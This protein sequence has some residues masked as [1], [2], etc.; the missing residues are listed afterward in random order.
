MFSFCKEK[1]KRIFVLVT[2]S[3]IFIPNLPVFAQASD[4]DYKSL[5]RI[6]EK[7][8]SKAAAEKNFED[9]VENY[10]NAVACEKLLEPQ[11]EKRILNLYHKLARAYG[12]QGEYGA[13]I[14]FSL[15]Y[16]KIAEEGGFETERRRFIA[17][18]I[19]IYD[20]IGTECVSKAIQVN[21]EGDDYEKSAE[22]YKA[23]FKYCEK[24]I[25][26]YDEYKIKDDMD[27]CMWAKDAYQSLCNVCTGLGTEYYGIALD[28]ARKSLEIKVPS[29]PP[30]TPEVLKEILTEKHDAYEKFFRKTDLLSYDILGIIHKI[31][32]DY[33]SAKE[34]YEKELQLLLSENS[35]NKET[36]EK[37][38][39]I[40]DSIADIDVAFGLYEN[41][42]YYY[43]EIAF[44][45][46]LDFDHKPE[47]YINS[48]LC[49]STLCI[50]MNDMDKA[51]EYARVAFE[52]SMEFYANNMGKIAESYSNYAGFFSTCGKYEKAEEYYKKAQ[53]IYMEE[54]K[55]DYRIAENTLSL[56]C[57]YAHQKRID[58]AKSMLEYFNSLSVKYPSYAEQ[59][60]LLCKYGFLME[61]ADDIGDK[62]LFL[63][64]APLF[65]NHIKKHSSVE[66]RIRNSGEILLFSEIASKYFG[67]EKII[68][69]KKDALE[70]ALDAIDE[71]VQMFSENQEKL[72]SNSLAIYYAGIE[73]AVS[74][75]EFEKAFLYSE[76]LRARGFLSEIG[77]KAALALQE[78]TESEKKKLGEFLIQIKLLKKETEENMDAEKIRKLESL[79]KELLE[80]EESIGE[81]VPKF[82]KLRNPKIASLSDCQKWCG[83]KRVILEYAI[84]D[85]SYSDGI[86]D[87]MLSSGKS[88]LVDIVEDKAK[89]VRSYCLVIT[90]KNI[91]AIEIDA[92]SGISEAIRTLREETRKGNDLNDGSSSPVRKK[93]AFQMKNHAE[94]NP[95]MSMKECR[96]FLYEKLIAPVLSEIPDDTE[97]I[98]IVPDGELS[99]IPFDILGNDDGELF[100]KRFAISLSPAISVSMMKAQDS[101]SDF[102][103]KFSI[104]N[105]SMLGIGN[106][107]YDEN[108]NSSEKR[109]AMT[110]ESDGSDVARAEFLSAGEYYRKRKISWRNIPGTGKE[111]HALRDSIFP[112]GKTVLYE[113][114]ET[115]ESLVK[116]LSEEGI[117]ANYPY[118]L[119]ACHGHFEE[120]EPAMSSLVFS[121]V[122]GK[123]DS[124]DDGY[125]TVQEVALLNMNARFLNL[126]ACETGLSA[127]KKGDGMSGLARACMVSGADNVG[128]TLWE[129][130]DEATVL[131]QT[132]LYSFIKSGM[133]YSESYRMAKMKM[134]E[135]AE[136]SKPVYWAAFT[137]Y[138]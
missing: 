1:I 101:K 27:I 60:F 113:G 52:M 91:R 66:N 62:E 123:I 59:S 40:Y 19:Q 119:L 136:F 81:R 39:D 24:A 30:D 130:N 70:I 33:V 6:Y 138:E 15:K 77:T 75:N 18:A 110:D 135:N 93:L 3:L 111:M 131:F 54:Y 61:I 53:A 132:T 23:A 58:E 96:K 90:G 74:Q 34:A 44:K 68:A 56:A 17:L 112:N 129:V 121:E 49:C 67:E 13:A 137:L 46:G 117:L 127:R 103:E 65:L 43:E 48:C 87:N 71:G 8:A 125:L 21:N 78:L 133:K 37:I 76:K 72:L 89:K 73:F 109:G 100:G 106:A 4:A 97:N 94:R 126:S 10:I 41:A 25:K 50:C 28:A 116:K 20:K 5:S 38:A 95:P 9:E 118:V 32:G 51:E 22:Y 86:K 84:Y 99:H 82:R 64:Y 92:G 115:T 7:K 105:F 35:G 83:K 98:V 79:K 122:S 107:M 120:S 102:D 128:V 31:A 124:A 29:V 2:I 114:K 63:E 104:E 42:L 16:A 26:I 45:N 57:L 14:G 11:N 85:E 88:A 80:L 55:T 69:L 108:E 47:L 134:M 12:H 36:Q